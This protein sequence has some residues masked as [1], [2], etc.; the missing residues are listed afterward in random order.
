MAW[1]MNVHHKDREYV[2][3][4]IFGGEAE[5]R[6]ACA[7]LRNARSSQLEHE[8]AACEIWSDAGSAVT[9]H[10]KIILSPPLFPDS[11]V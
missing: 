8:T 7:R 2:P 9:L 10:A 11:L 3:R 5:R 1:L 6:R 4:L